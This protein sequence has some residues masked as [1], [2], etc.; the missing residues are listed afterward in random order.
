MGSVRRALRP[1]RSHSSTVFS[2]L[3]VARVCPSGAKATA[4]DDQTVLLWD[5]SGLNARRADPVER[6]CSLSGGGLDADEWGRSIPDLAYVDSCS[7]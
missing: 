2:P 6:A 4:S 5:L 7:Q 1:L 3:A